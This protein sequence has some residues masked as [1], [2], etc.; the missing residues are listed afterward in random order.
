MSETSDNRFDHSP[1][2]PEAIR[3]L[4]QLSRRSPNELPIRPN[5]ESYR[6][7]VACFTSANKRTTRTPSWQRLSSP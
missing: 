7:Q 4:R 2:P 5:L 1:F 3:V 6:K